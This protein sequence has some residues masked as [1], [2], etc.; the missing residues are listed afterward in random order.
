MSSAS[1]RS[2][3]CS[4]LITLIPNPD[5][6]SSSGRSVYRRSHGR[7]G[8][9]QAKGQPGPGKSEADSARNQVVQADTK[10]IGQSP[11][12]AHGTGPATRFDIGGIVG[13][14]VRHGT[15]LEESPCKV[16]IFA[17]VG[18]A[19]AILWI[20]WSVIGGRSFA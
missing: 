20:I 18:S 8:V 13:R 10:S 19:I 5:S 2:P 4:M 17:A 15:E 12:R 7:N 16:A 6:G 1:I 9:S 14:A 3:V 11:E